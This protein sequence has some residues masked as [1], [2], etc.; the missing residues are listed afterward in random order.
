M[1]ELDRLL[2][3]TQ[4]RR[5]GHTGKQAN[6]F[7]AKAGLYDSYVGGMFR[8]MVVTVCGRAGCYYLLLS[9][10]RGISESY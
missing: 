5:D 10:E 1:K 2:A 9:L 7:F 8:L 3:I 6:L 4:Q